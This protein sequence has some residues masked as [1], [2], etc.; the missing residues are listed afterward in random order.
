MAEGRT[1]SEVRIGPCLKNPSQCHTALN[2]MRGLLVLIPSSKL[3][4]SIVQC[5]SPFIAVGVSMVYNGH[6]KGVGMKHHLSMKANIR[7]AS[8]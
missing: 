1:A 2:L 7:E 5:T 3:K 8:G 4:C 6:Q